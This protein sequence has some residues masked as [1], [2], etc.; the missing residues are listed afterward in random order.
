[1]TAPGE[2]WSIEADAGAGRGG[3]PLQGPRQGRRPAPLRPVLAAGRRSSRRCCS[4]SAGKHYESNL[5]GFEFIADEAC[6]VNG[7]AGHR[8]EFRHTPDKGKPRRADEVVWRKAGSGY[9]LALDVEE[10]AYEEI[11]PSFATLLASFE[12]LEGK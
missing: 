4:A 12:D 6:T 10:S 1:M 5:K 7:L 2:G 3:H 8:A 9:L 11:K